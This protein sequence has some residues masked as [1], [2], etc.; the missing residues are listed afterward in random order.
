MH[1]LSYVVRFAERAIAI[2]KENNAVSVQKLVV[3]VGEMTDVIPEYLQKYYPEAAKGT[4]L[5]GSL[6]E[7]EPL[8]AKIHCNSCGTDFHPEREQ[9]YL[10]PA[11]GS[12]NGKILE[13]RHVV[14]K[15]VV[16]ET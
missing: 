16:M 5:E 1:E 15:E 10:C 13:G 2:A 6:L 12:G 9:N 3:Q 7:T 14:L 11:C 8:P 4:I